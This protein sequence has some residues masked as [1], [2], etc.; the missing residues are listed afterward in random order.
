MA[1]KGGLAD[2]AAQVLER[3]SVKSP[4]G[5]RVEREAVGLWLGLPRPLGRNGGGGVGGLLPLLYFLW[6]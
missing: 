6:G 1:T 2:R 4:P 3:W 5:E